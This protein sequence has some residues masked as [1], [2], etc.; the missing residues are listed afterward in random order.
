LGDIN[1]KRRS[2]TQTVVGREA[3]VD[4]CSA[5]G[6]MIVSVGPMSI[7]LERADAEDLVETLEMALLL[8]GRDGKLR[9]ASANE[10]PAARRAE[11][12]S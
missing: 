11:A 6:G 7:W 12:A 10:A 9:P 3:Q 5:D 4:F 2:G 8:S 1:M